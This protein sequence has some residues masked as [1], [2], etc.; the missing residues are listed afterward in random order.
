MKEKMREKKDVR[1]RVLN[2]KKES[3][4]KEIIK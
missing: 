3:E 4:K 2:K 1:M